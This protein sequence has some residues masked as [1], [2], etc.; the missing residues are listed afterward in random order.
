MWAD[1][2][3]YCRAKYRYKVGFEILS[4]WQMSAMGTVLSAC[5]FFAIWTRGSSTAMDCERPTDS[6]PAAPALRNRLT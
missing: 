2:S 5:I 4:V 3:P 1:F 6:A